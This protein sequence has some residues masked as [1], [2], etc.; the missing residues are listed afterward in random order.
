[1]QKN[2]FKSELGIVIIGR[3]EG[4]RLR[5]SCMSALREATNIVYVDSGS[6]DSSIIIAKDASL[7]VIELDRETAFTAARARNEGY[8]YLVHKF[9]TIKFIQFVDGDCELI[10]GWCQEAINQIN[11]DPTIAIV[12]GKLLEIN[13]EVSVYNRMGDFEWNFVKPGIVEAVGGIFMVR[14]SAFEQVGGFNSSIPAGEEPELCQRLR[15]K[16]FIIVR[17]DRHMAWHDLAMLYFTQWWIRQIRGGYGGFDV[18]LRFGI[19]RYA[20][21][22]LRAVVWSSLGGATILFIIL[23]ICTQNIFGF[24]FLSAG[25]LCLFCMQFLRISFSCVRK[26]QVGWN[27]AFK[28]SFFT[29]LSL[30][31]QFFGI[32]QYGFDFLKNNKVRL[33]EYKR[34]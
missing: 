26:T 30:F 9:P 25:L 15:Q 33:I 20:R 17:L 32:I 13:P 7:P 8:K 31:G 27:L 6:T 21:N 23:L 22:A 16:D 5:S 1:V 24:G 4:E 28:Y 10:E 12:A 2:N 11:T 3:N 29:M 18:A 34:K 19:K 14:C